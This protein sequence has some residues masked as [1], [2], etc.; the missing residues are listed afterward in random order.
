MDLNNVE[1]KIRY[2]WMAGIVPV[3]FCLYI[4]VVYGIIS[5]MNDIELLVGSCI[6]A[7]LPLDC[8]LAYIREAE[9]VQ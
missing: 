3:V 4:L 6:W 2:A 8:L 5:E 9:Y 7:A 1:K